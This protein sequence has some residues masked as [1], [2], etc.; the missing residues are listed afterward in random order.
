MGAAVTEFETVLYEERDL[1]AHVTLNRPERHNAFNNQMQSELREI[2]TS[3]RRNDD[4]RAVVLTGAGDRAFCSGIDRD[5]SI[6]GS[7]EPDDG[8][9]ARVGSVSTPLMF[10]DPGMNIC[11]KQCD[12]WKPVIAAVNGMACGGALY[13]LGECDIII[14]AEHATFFDPHVT[15]N[16]VSSFEAIH[17]LQKLPLGE[18]IRLILL[19]AHERMSAQRAFDVGLASEVVP[20]SDL[21]DRAGWVANA[22]ASAEP[23]VIQASL[24]AIW[25]GHEH[26][27]RQALQL[28]RTFV[29]LGTKPELI[30][31]GQDVFASGK[32]IDWQLR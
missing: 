5:E 15:Y 7:A 31:A 16:M 11:P 19:G 9:R 27:W 22:I 18:T 23:L 12:L 2:W 4:V 13:I 32:R 21:A 24:Q 26:S 14:A 10:D 29:G 30:A 28:A 1:V 17:L 6:A 3:L 8:A 25:A 20:L